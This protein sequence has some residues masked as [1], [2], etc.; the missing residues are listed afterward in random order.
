MAFKNETGDATEGKLYQTKT[1]THCRWCVKGNSAP[2]PEA[3]SN[4]KQMNK[5]VVA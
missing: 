4:G 3:S 5:S 2:P 1:Y